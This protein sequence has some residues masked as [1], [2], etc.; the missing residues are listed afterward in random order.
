MGEMGLLGVPYKDYGCPG[1]SY[2]GY[3]LLA[4]EVE[5]VD[6]GYRSAM[7]VQTSLV[8]GPIHDYGYS[9]CLYFSQNLQFF[10]TAVVM[11]AEGMKRINTS[12]ILYI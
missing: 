1:S 10:M 4:K 7:S 12:S 2:V 11:I 8:I 6:S 5:A 3:G 9:C